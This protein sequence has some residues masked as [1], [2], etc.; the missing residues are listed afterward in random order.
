MVTAPTPIEEY[1]IRVNRYFGVYM[2]AIWGF[3]LVHKQAEQAEAIRLKNNPQ[4][5]SYMSFRPDNFD[6]NGPKKLSHEEMEDRSINMSTTHEVIQRNLLGGQNTLTTKQ[7]VIS[8]IFDIWDKPY[9]EEI[10]DF[11]SFESENDLK[12]PVLGD[13]RIFRNSIVHKDGRAS[14]KVR[15]L[16]VYKWFSPDEYI[17]FTHDQM[18]EIKKYFNRQ[19]EID[20][21]KCQENNQQTEEV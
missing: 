3:N 4:N 11:L 20:C 15:N 9:R 10:A 6:P 14:S 2:D 5:N 1:V 17:D 16:E 21:M 13:L 7:M 12:I 19:F 8:S 18:L